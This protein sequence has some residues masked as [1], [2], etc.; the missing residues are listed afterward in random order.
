MPAENLEIPEFPDRCI[1]WSIYTL[2]VVIFGLL[3]AGVATSG[4]LP[5]LS[6]GTWLLIA[7]VLGGLMALVI[8]RTR[9]KYER[10]AGT[11]RLFYK[12]LLRQM[13]SD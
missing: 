7:L 13:P 3:G 11:W 4:V 5:T 9:P 1:S 2:T 12:F 10:A 8:N 6:G